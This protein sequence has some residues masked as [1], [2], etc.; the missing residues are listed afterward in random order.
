MASSISSSEVAEAAR[1]I[2]EGLSRVIVGSGGVS[3]QVLASAMAGGH[4][5]LEGVPGVAK[6]T[7]ARAL[8]R[9]LGVENA[10]TELDGVVHR[11]FRRIQFTPD[12]LPGDVT[13]SLVY[14]PDRREFVFKPG[15]VFSYL[16]LADEINRAVPRTQSALLEAMQERQVTVG[17][18][19]YRLED[20]AAGKWFL[21]IATQNPV[22]QEG[23]FPLPEA[24]LDR[25]MTRVFVSYPP[26][27]EDEVNVLRLHLGRLREPLEELEPVVDPGWLLEARRHVARVAVPDDILAYIARVVRATRPEEGATAGLLSLGASPRAGIMLAR[28]SQALALIRGRPAVSL[29]EVNDALFPVLNHRLL[30]D[31]D[32]LLEYEDKY[33]RAQARR[34]LVEDALSRAVKA[35]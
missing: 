12:L 7:L 1:A 28:Y 31:P 26:G 11:G 8:A 35:G 20:E 16:L 17:G 3:E 18:V 27:V 19:S 21:V 14:D 24:Q 33:G 30:P 34:R 2:L 9:L 32:A 13:G 25:F 5:L 22:E 10:R 29:D 23:T 15:P 4:V 6:T